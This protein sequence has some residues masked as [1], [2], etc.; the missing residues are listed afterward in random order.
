MIDIA[1]E[2]LISLAEAA[3]MLPCGRK[4][5]YPNV[6]TVYAWTIHGCRG[7]VLE[8]LQLAGRR[9]TSKEAVHRFIQALTAAAGTPRSVTGR[10]ATTSRQAELEAEL[11]RLGVKADDR[12][13]SRG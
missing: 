13:V 6:K 4:G 7:I 11:D 3:G 8:T 1:S 5:R 10:G 2:Q 9:A 12:E